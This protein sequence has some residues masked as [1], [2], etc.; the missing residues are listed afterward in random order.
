MTCSFYILDYKY[1]IF[2]GL[3]PSEREC[4]LTLLMSLCSGSRSGQ[5]PEEAG[6]SCTGG[7]RQAVRLW[8]WVLM[9][10][11][12]AWLQMLTAVAFVILSGKSLSLPISSSSL[13]LD[14]NH[15]L[16]AFCYNLSTDICKA[17]LY[18]SFCL[19]LGYHFNISLISVFP[20]V[21]WGCF[22]HFLG[23]VR[24]CICTAW[25]VCSSFVKHF[26]FQLQLSVGWRRLTD[27][28]SVY[29]PISL[30]LCLFSLFSISLSDTIKQ[31]HISKPSERGIFLS[32]LFYS[33]LLCL[34]SPLPVVT[35]LSSRFA[36][37]VVQF[38]GWLFCSAQLT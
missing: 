30:S 29:E 15:R 9:G 21:E 13:S 38:I 32:F 37:C 36:L 5:H 31:K 17:S 7:Q 12:R 2:A 28:L 34:L 19:S 23:V 3:I 1:P 14:V 6:Y 35:F 22:L 33:S 4:V 25:C 24:L 27:P 8:Q 26:H 16:S 11:S 20:W 10:E 18:F